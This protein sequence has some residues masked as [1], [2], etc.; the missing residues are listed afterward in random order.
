MDFTIT[1]Q[2]ARG[3][4]HEL[5]Y[6]ESSRDKAVHVMTCTSPSFPGE[7]ATATRLHGE[8]DWIVWGHRQVGEPVRCHDGPTRYR[9]R[10]TE[11][12]QMMRQFV[13]YGQTSL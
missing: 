10:R 5:I 13:V 12:Q 6:T 11:A 9:L 7:W 4:R 1:Y 3:D 8:R 2:T